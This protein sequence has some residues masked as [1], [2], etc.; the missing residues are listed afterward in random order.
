[1]YTNFTMMTDSALS[2]IEIDI[3][4]EP[5]DEA[6]EGQLH[7]EG[8]GESVFCD[9]TKKKSWRNVR[10][11]CNNCEFTCD[12]KSEMLRHK[13][14]CHIG[15]MKKEHRCSQCNEFRTVVR[16]ALHEHLA[17]E[18]GITNPF[19]CKTCGFSAKTRRIV[20]IHEKQGRNS[21]NMSCRK[22]KIRS[23]DMSKLFY[24]A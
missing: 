19:Q 17:A 10:H 11:R 18:H 14:D 5:L 6:I 8:E 13:L 4:E 24:M 23:F 15:G 1:M 22:M 12:K 7:A 3:K 2:A 9:D 16:F 20:A 21:C